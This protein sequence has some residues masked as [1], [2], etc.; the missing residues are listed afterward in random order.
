MRGE[1]PEPIENQFAS[2]APLFRGGGGQEREERQSRAIGPTSPKKRKVD[3]G[4]TPSIQ[5][6]SCLQEIEHA[7]AK[8]L[9]AVQGADATTGC[10]GRVRALQEEVQEIKKLQL[11]LVQLIKSVIPGSETSRQ[12]IRGVPTVPE[13]SALPK[14]AEGTF[15]REAQQQSQSSWANVAGVGPGNG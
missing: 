2:A 7:I 6:H 15:N 5:E 11:H 14:D 4:S 13:N 1:A 3:V 9:C 12:K 10:G 8:A